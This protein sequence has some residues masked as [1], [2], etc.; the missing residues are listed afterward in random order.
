MGQGL[1]GMGTGLATG[2]ADG[3]AD[4]GLRADTLVPDPP[5]GQ[6]PPP[7]RLAVI[8]AAEADAGFIAAPRTDPVSASRTGP[9]L[10]PPSFLSPH[11]WVR[12]LRLFDPPP[13]VRVLYAV[14]EGPPAQFL[15]R[16]R[17]CRV[18]RWQGPERIAPEWWADRPGTRLRDY[19][20]VE[21]DAGRRLWL[22]REG[23]AG[24]G[25]GGA[26]RWFVH[27]VFA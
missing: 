26:P 22:F 4:P 13:E 20:R 5:A 25:R 21:D 3:R 12:P 19:Y 2:G 1:A 18:A 9:G 14:P 15:W 23:V 6:S 27:G 16:G 17:A 7:P 11:P 24:D 10:A 8:P